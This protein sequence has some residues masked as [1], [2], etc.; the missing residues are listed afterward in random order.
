MK[1][2]VTAMRLSVFFKIFFFSPVNIRLEDAHILA[3]SV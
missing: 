1:K 3:F 2:K